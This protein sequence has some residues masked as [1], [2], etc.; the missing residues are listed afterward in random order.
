MRLTQI[1]ERNGPVFAADIPFAL[2][3]IACG[4]I[5]DSFADSPET[6]TK[7][8]ASDRRRANRRIRRVDDGVDRPVM[9]LIAR[10]LAHPGVY[11][12]QRSGQA[13]HYARAPRRQCR[14]GI[15]PRAEKM[16]P[17]AAVGETR[18]CCAT[19]GAPSMAVEWE[20]LLE[21]AGRPTEMALWYHF[22]IMFE[23]LFI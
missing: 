11:F 9:A 10:L 23:G 3:T 19:G 8:L 16:H 15:H 18:P 4:A 2:Y 1:H 6:T 7:L 5:S 17:R 12:D 13:S 21:R 20:S 14:T 22:A